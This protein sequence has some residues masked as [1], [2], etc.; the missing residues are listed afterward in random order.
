MF[1]FE[2]HLVELL[3]RAVWFIPQVTQV[4]AKD[5]RLMT[6]RSSPQVRAI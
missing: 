4:T 6:D 2:N 5:F 1:K 3:N